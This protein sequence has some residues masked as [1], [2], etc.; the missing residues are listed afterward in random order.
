MAATAAA[1]EKDSASEILPCDDGDIALIGEG[2]VRVGDGRSRDRLAA[3]DLA[4]QEHAF[5]RPRE[6]V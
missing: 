3:L 4:G 2:E 6:R 1:V 5:R